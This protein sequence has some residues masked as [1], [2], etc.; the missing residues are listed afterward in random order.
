[1]TNPN[2][3][4]GSIRDHREGFMRTVKSR[5]LSI[6]LL[7]VFLG[8]NIQAQEKKG[9]LSSFKDSEDG[10]FD[11]SDYLLNKKGFLIEPTIITEPAVGYGLALALVWFHSSYGEQEHPP[12]MSG[13]V[14]MGTENESWGAGIFHFGYWKQ[15]RI[16]YRGYLIKAG[17]NIAYYGSGNYGILGDKSINANLDTWI[18]S[19]QLTFRLGKSDFFAG[20]RYEY[21]P[22]DIAFEIPIDIPEFEGIEFSSTLSEASALVF[23]DTRNNIF[24]PTRGVYLEMSGTYADT[25]FGAETLYGRVQAIGLGFFPASDR[26]NFGIRYDTQFSLGDVPWWARPWVDLRGAPLV[27]YQNK[28]TVVMEAQVDWNIYKRW[29]LL[30]FT[31]IG[32]AFSDFGDF[33]KGKSVRT[34][35]T[36][37][38]YLIARKLGAQMGIDVAFSNDDWAFYIV[39]GS[40]WAK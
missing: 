28:N 21:M 3:G 24:T 32:H 39:F 38:R 23:Y 13:V 8:L 30:G 25:W 10:A 4:S 35:G 19:Q 16:R 7:G 36:G 31:G 22:T 29:T 18:L 26:V 20:V 5:I 27:K 11:L 37:F 12:S 6:L 40:P 33:D 17:L 15:D 1:M 2:D 14:G 34:V 9:W